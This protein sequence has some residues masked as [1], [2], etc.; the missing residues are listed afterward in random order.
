MNRV[1]GSRDH[2]WL[3]VYGGLATM[4]WHGRSGAWKAVVIAQGG[5][6][7]GTVVRVLTNGATWRWS[8]R[9]GHMMAL[10]RGG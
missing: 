4:G 6:E 1:Y 8:C 9:D 3:S 5:R 2:D 10:N 7:R